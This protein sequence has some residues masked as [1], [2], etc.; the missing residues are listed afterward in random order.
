MSRA[1]YATLPITPETNEPCERADEPGVE[2]M[3][4]PPADCS[5]YDRIY[6]VSRDDILTYYATGELTDDLRDWPYQLGA[7]VIDGD[8]LP[9]DPW[10]VAAPAAS[11]DVPLLIGSNKDEA[12]IYFARYPNAG[13]L[14]EPLD[15]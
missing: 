3:A 4:A 10:G 8:V 13:A 6:A 11:R 2:S 15:P 1:A 7:P 14:S 5:E 9:A 12:A